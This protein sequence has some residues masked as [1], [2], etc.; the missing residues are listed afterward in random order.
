MDIY[1]CNLN[2]RLF[3]SRV[4]ES[5]RNRNRSCEHKRR[6]EP[7]KHNKQPRRDI[8]RAIDHLRVAQHH[9]L[10]ERNGA[11]GMPRT[12]VAQHDR[13]LEPVRRRVLQPF[14]QPTHHQQGQLHRGLA[15]PCP[16]RPL[17]IGRGLFGG[18]RFVRRDR[19]RV[20][21]ILDYCESR[22]SRIVVAYRE[23]K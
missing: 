19:L 22:T 5:K 3:I 8:R 4:R 6:F 12:Q 13:H 15:F 18:R 16:N 17:A 20:L 10:L 11:T 23:P 21:I 9:S 14:A 2:S 7:N 1:D